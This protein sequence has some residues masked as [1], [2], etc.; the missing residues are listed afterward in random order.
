MINF[1]EQIKAK[2]AELGINSGYAL[3]KIIGHK[4]TNVAV[5]NYLKGKSEMTAANLELIINTLAELQKTKNA[6]LYK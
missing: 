3:T 2:M 6:D 4:I 5:D 1:R